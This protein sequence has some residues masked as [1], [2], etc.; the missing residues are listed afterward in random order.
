M[1]ASI[2]YGANSFEIVTEV[3][4][5]MEPQEEVAKLGSGDDSKGSD[6]VLYRGKSGAR[7]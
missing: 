3:L 5:A 1:Q 7:G 6:R 4:G 2:P